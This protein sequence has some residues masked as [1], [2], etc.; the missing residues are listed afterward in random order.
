MSDGRI[1]LRDDEGDDE[2]KGGLEREREGDE[3]GKE[4]E[5]TVRERKDS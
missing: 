3:A 4:R 2:W 5:D 1:I